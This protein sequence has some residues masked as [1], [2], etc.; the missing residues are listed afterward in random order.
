MAL[1]CAPV[2]MAL[3]APV[4]VEMADTELPRQAVA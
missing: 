4:V 3:T 1:G 2:A